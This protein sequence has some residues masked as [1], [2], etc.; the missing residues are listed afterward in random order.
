MAKCEICGSKIMGESHRIV[1]DGA[2]M[3]V[4]GRCSRLGKPARET[5][6]VAA[7][8]RSPS[9]AVMQVYRRPAAMVP[10]DQLVLRED[11]SAVLRKAREASG[12]TQEQLGMKLNEKSSVVGK[13]ESGKLKPSVALAKKLEHLMKIRLFE[14]ESS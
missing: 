11:Y 8:Q 1:V 14:T 10:D 5:T 9:E 12:L 6:P 2:I 3:N 4:C 7:A 13:L